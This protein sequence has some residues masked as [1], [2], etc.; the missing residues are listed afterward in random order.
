MDEDVQHLVLNGITV[1][2][3]KVVNLANPVEGQTDRI[4]QSIDWS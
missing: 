4:D 2:R 1:K 3:V